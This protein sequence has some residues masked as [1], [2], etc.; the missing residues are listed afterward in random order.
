MRAGVVVI[1]NI[2]CKTK[3]STADLQG[4]WDSFQSEEHAIDNLIAEV[5]FR[6]QIPNY[7]R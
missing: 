3:L 5:R 6:K 7:K 4:K 2:Q 1:V